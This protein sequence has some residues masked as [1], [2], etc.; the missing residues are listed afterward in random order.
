VKARWEDTDLLGP[1]IRIRR[2]RIDEAEARY[3]WF[4]NPMVTKFL[5]L[6]GERVLP[7]DNVLAFLEQ[8]SR[9]DDPNMSVGI[10]L[11]SGRLIGC[12]GLRS[13]VRGESAEVSIVIGEPDVWGLGYGRE[14]MGLLLQFGF[15]RLNLRTIWLVVRTENSRAVSLFDRLGFVAVDTIEAAVIVGGIAR[16]KL[17]MD[18]SSESWRAR[19]AADG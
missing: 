17:R 4:A 2:A 11:L 6:A 10:E 1:R 3:R 13:I 12:G 9:D 5:P 16:S 14:A 19:A 15:E 7:M 18:L 8:A